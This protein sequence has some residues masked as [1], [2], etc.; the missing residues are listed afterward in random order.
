[1]PLVIARRN[2]R[3]VEYLIWTGGSGV[4][5]SA[6]Y[7]LE[8]AVRVRISISFPAL[9]FYT[10]KGRGTQESD[11]VIFFRS[12]LDSKGIFELMG[13]VLGLII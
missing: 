12:R 1:M 5:G 2:G 4:G 6:F 10:K 11:T 8:S 3:R 13:G 7:N 9:L